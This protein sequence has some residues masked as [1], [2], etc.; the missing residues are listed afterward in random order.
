MSYKIIK[1]YDHVIDDPRLKTLEE[2]LVVSYVWSW[3]V[4]DKCCFVYDAFLSR[5]T[6]LNE[7]D[8]YKLLTSLQKRRILK[9][10]WVNTRTLSI[11]V[12]GE[13]S[14]CGDDTDIF[15]L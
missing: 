10:N 1:L 14:P 2:R 4:Q 11:I 15:E 3:Q 9:I 13:E 8:L 6:S 5:I 12:D 7:S